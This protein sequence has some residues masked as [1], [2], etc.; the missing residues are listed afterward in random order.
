MRCV[1]EYSAAATPTLYY[2]CAFFFV[3]LAMI[4]IHNKV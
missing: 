2:K 4:L 3:L 1:N